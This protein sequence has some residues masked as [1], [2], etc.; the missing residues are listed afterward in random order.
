MV[1]VDVLVLEKLLADH[2]SK[3]ILR[4]EVPI[5]IATAAVVSRL[6]GHP[7]H[8]V[9]LVH[10]GALPG[11]HGHAG[12]HHEGEQEVHGECVGKRGLRPV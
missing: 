2:V 7:G 5:V 11:G 8:R 9:G 10:V 1:S 3:R 4:A 6:H 12:A